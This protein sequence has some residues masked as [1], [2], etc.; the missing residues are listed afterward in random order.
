MKTVLVCPD[1][2]SVVLFCRPI[3]KALRAVSAELLVAADLGG[4]GAE[5]EALGV[6]PVQVPIARYANPLRDLAYAWRLRRLFRR[7]RAD[8]VFNFSTKPNLYG[9]IAAHLAG[10]PRVYAHVV[11]LGSVFSMPRGPKRWV[12]ERVLLG[13]YSLGARASDRVWFTNRH[14]LE[15]FV[16]KGLVTPDRAVLTR[17]YLDTRKTYTPD[18][19]P[20]ADVEALR[21]ELGLTSGERVVVMVARL[22]WSKGIGEFVDAA[23]RLAATHPQLRFVLVAPE[24]HGSA[25]V[26]PVAWVTDPARPANFRWVGFRRDV[27][28]F[29]AMADVA[30]LPSYYREGGYPRGLLEPMAMGKPLVATDTDGCRG[31]VDEG[32]NGYLVPPRDGAA[33]AGAIARIFDEPGRLEAFGRASREK[34]VREFEDDLIVPSAIAAL[35]L[36][37]AR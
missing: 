36:G 6:R 20:A 5:I 24:E 18:C 17:N 30:V 4:Y 8:A 29:Y 21:R 14:D 16:A 11:G 33:L 28:R 22:I 26:V 13:L 15:F 12:L 19:V 35:G 10:V 9:G 23:G 37:A 1:G 27:P 7:E 25:E 3:I 31:T 32:L 34:A 2:L